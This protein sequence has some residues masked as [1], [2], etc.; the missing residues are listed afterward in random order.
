NG[1]ASG[2]A[3]RVNGNSD[4]DISAS[5]F[6]SNM[7]D[8]SGGAL[9]IGT[10]ANVAIG[11]IVLAGN[12]AAGAAA[13]GLDGGVLEAVHITAN[14]N[15]TCGGGG[16][17]VVGSGGDL[18][19][20]NSIVGS[21]GEMSI[22]VPGGTASV[23]SSNIRGGFAGT[24]N[25]NNDPQFE[26]ADG[27]DNIVG[28]PDD[29]LHLM[30]TSPCID[31]GD[32]VVLLGPPLSGKDLSGDERNIYE[33]PDMGAYEFR[34]PGDTD[35]DGVVTFSD[36]NDLLDAWGQTNVTAAEGD[37]DFDGDVDFAD[38]NTLLEWWDQSCR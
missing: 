6:R 9:L 34:C 10:D 20:A 19:M 5:F 27:P 37:T 14:G 17:I 8:T 12:S 22:L 24:G 33:N 7:A 29:N 35:G 13:I 4:L 31:T 3:L 26:D 38:L 11:N 16:I 36:L 18:T 23:E 15:T 28:T 30:S 25:I 2:G 32:N 1:A 21:P